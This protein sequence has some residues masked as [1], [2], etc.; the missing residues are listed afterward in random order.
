M[1]K[2]EDFHNKVGQIWQAKC[3]MAYLQGNIRVKSV[4]DHHDTMVIHNPIQFKWTFG[5]TYKT[6]F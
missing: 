6:I 3:E 2:I 4:C 5:E 1:I